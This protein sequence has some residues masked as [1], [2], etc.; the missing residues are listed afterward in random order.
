[1]DLRLTDHFPRVMQMQ[2]WNAK[3]KIMHFYQSD[4][5]ISTVEKWCLMKL[6]KWLK[7][8]ESIVTHG[9][10]QNRLVFRKKMHIVSCTYVRRTFPLI[11]TTV[12]LLMGP[13][14]CPAAASRE[15]GSRQKEKA[16]EPVTYQ[17]ITSW[18]VSKL[19]FEC[20]GYAEDMLF[21]YH[22]VET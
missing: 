9:L 14:F 15:P 11:F 10:P 22:N 13:I 19:L 20:R 7:Q 4:P 8:T 21:Y 3:S 18:A 6:G 17:K 16:T 5:P 2:N 12:W 1:M